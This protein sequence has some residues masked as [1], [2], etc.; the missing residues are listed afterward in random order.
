[1]GQ[2]A[3]KVG[4]SRADLERF[5]ELTARKQ[6][7]DRESRAIGSSLAVLSAK[8]KQF[9]LQESPRERAVK[10]LG[11]LLR[12]VAKPGTVSWKQAFITATS[13]YD[14]KRLQEEAPPRDVL[15]VTKA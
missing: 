5:A 13:E 14:A 1:M 8:F 15:E 3:E 7:L 10:R 9:V 2:T 4:V 11:W 6:D 12:I